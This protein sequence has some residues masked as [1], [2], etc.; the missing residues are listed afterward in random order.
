MRAEGTTAST[1]GTSIG[2]DAIT[3]STSGI[4]GVFDN[5]AGGKILSGRANG[6]EEFDV[7]G[8]GAVRATGYQDLAGNPITGSATQILY[9]GTVST[10]SSATPTL[11]GTIG[12]SNKAA[13]GT[14]ITTTWISHVHRG[15]GV[16]GGLFCQ[17]EV[18][19]DDAVPTGQ[20]PGGDGAIT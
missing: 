7:D 18:R 13:A 6:V 8:G 3:N 4:A 11:F 20:T 16:V 2:V 19:I 15:N 12:T 17:F 10:T 1:T 9:V 14:A 5:K